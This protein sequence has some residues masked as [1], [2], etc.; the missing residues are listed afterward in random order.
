MVPSGVGLAFVQGLGAVDSQ[1]VRPELR[2]SMEALVARIACGE[3]QKG[4]VVSGGLETFRQQFDKLRRAMH[5]L[6]PF[7][8]DL[9]QT[10]KEGEGG[11][12]ELIRLELAAASGKQTAC[13]AADGTLWRTP[14]DREAPTNDPGW[15]QPWRAGRFSARMRQ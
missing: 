1:L 7:F 11:Q 4:E 12:D 9:G 2:A 13:G 15:P 3:A 14:W 6:V 5:L 8:G 10:D